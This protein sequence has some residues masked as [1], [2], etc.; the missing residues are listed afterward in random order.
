MTVYTYALREFGFG[1]YQVTAP[2]GFVLDESGSMDMALAMSMV[3]GSPQQTVQI[4][5]NFGVYTINRVSAVG[6]DLA[7]RVQ[8]AARF[9]VTIEPPPDS[10]AIFAGMQREAAEIQ[11][12]E[13]LARQLEADVAAEPPGRHCLP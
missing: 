11:A 3:L 7:S 8:S 2:Q 12:I 10:S 13:A 6:G 4:R 9:N 1:T 5:G